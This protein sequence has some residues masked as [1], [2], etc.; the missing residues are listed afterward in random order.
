[1]PPI[2]CLGGDHVVA[3]GAG[4]SRDHGG[5]VVGVALNALIEPD[6]SSL[7]LEPWPRGS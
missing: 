3:P 4:R 1:M 6:A 7:E 2:E 5:Q